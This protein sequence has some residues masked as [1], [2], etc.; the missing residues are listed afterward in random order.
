MPSYPGNVVEAFIDLLFPV[1]STENP[2]EKQLDLSSSAKSGEEHRHQKLVSFS[3]EEHEEMTYEY[4]VNNA[5]K[6]TPQVSK[7]HSNSSSNKKAPPK[8]VV[9][10]SMYDELN[11]RAAKRT[12]IQLEKAQQ[13]QKYE[14]MKDKIKIEKQKEFLHFE[15]TEQRFRYKCMTGIHQ[16]QRKLK[17][18]QQ[19]ALQRQREQRMMAENEKKKELLQ[20]QLKQNKQMALQRQRDQRMMAALPNV[21]KNSKGH[22][23]HRHSRKR[24]A[25]CLPRRYTHRGSNNSSVSSGCG[26]YDLDSTDSSYSD[27][28]ETLGKK[29]DNLMDSVADGLLV[30]LSSLPS[31]RRSR[32]R[33]N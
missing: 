27:D 26:S 3:C 22:R 20:R 7:C 29:I 24:Y 8:Q 9:T 21:L 2:D 17:Q 33:R 18:N 25:D 32:R 5:F 16:K 15:K 11:D 14:R 19:L 23:E 13:R 1:S 10:K 4:H 30:M 6:P 31:A 28:A 12:V